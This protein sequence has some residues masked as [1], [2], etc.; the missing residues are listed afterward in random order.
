MELNCLCCTRQIMFA[1]SRCGSDER[2]AAVMESLLWLVEEVWP[3]VS[4][5]SMGQPVALVGGRNLGSVVQQLQQ[6][7]RQVYERDQIP[8][9]VGTRVW[10]LKRVVDAVDAKAVVHSIS[11]AARDAGLDG[12]DDIHNV[13]YWIGTE[14]EENLR[15]MRSMLRTP[16]NDLAQVLLN[17]VMLPFD[18]A[19]ARAVAQASDHQHVYWYMRAGTTVLVATSAPSMQETFRKLSAIF[20][21]GAL[22][23]GRVVPSTAPVSW[24]VD[25]PMTTLAVDNSIAFVRAA[26]ATL[27][28]TGPLATTVPDN[29]DLN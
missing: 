1:T 24:A 25:T 27:K 7:G 11:A 3:V 26:C 2:E 6:V 19:V 22:A 18:K 14:F 10:D 8:R 21:A 23:L 20:V 16:E 4:V 12:E 29:D 17:I 28:I 9:P 5:Q 15:V 13:M